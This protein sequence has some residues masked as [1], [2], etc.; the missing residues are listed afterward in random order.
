MAIEVDPRTADVQRLAHLHHLGFSRLSLG[1]Q[2]TDPQV[3]KAIHRVQSTD[4]IEALRNHAQALGFESVN[5]DL[6]YGLPRQSL[7]SFDRTLD[8]VARLRPDRLALYAYAHLPA[9]FKPQ[10]R[11][12]EDDLPR[13]SERLQLLER[14]IDRLLGEGYVYIGM[15]HFALPTDALAIARHQGR[16]HRNFQGYTATPD[17]DVMGLGPSAIGRV[18]P[19]YFQNHHDLAAWQKA[20]TGGQF[21]TNRGCLLTRDDLV[22][23]SVIMAL[24]CQGEVAFESIE[25]AHLIRFSEYFEQELIALERWQEAGMVHRTRD[26][27]ELTDMGW[28]GVRAIA[29]EFDAHRAHAGAWAM[30]SR[31][32]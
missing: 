22:R 8:V 4:T 29:M 3:Q 12:L 6:M 17:V 28:F 21:A 7:E 23:R 9:R 24:M 18:G 32:T 11:I 30:A 5:F 19:R 26:G 27:L 10:R 2:D 31:L 25:L 14:A 13:P 15:D 16:L 1:V 20:V